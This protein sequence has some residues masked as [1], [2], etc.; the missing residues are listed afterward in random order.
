MAFSSQMC[1]YSF[2]RKYGKQKSPWHLL[3]IIHNIDIL[4]VFS[5]WLLITP[6]EIPQE[7]QQLPSWFY[8]MMRLE[9]TQSVWTLH[10][11]ASTLTCMQHSPS[12][13]DLRPFLPPPFLHENTKSIFL[14]LNLIGTK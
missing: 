1:L 10:K 6:L 8:P 11:F 9:L 5:L 14:H 12:S 2:I 3:F 7:T 4:Y 13:C